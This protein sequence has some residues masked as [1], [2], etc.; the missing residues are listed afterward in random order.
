MDWLARYTRRSFLTQLIVTFVALVLV[1]AAA[2]G[3][4]A[5]YIISSALEKQAWERIEDAERITRVALEAEQARL[6]SVARLAAGRPSLQQLVRSGEFT[7][8]AEYLE[9]FRSGGAL[10]LLAVFDPLGRVLASSGTLEIEPLYSA[11]AGYRVDS[12]NR[13]ALV[14]SQS[15]PDNQSTGVAGYVVVGI[16]LDDDF[17]RQLAVETGFEQSIL[18]N[19]SRIATSLDNAPPQTVIPSEAQR[20]ETTNRSRQTEFT[21]RGIHYYA[22]FVP[23][24][25]VQGEVIGLVEIVM[26]VDSLMTARHRALLALAFSALTVAAVG[27]LLGSLYARWLTAPLKR[28]TLVAREIGHGDLRGPVPVL[29]RPVEFTTLAAA[30]DESR[31]KIRRTLDELSRVKTWSEMLIQSM[32]EGVVTFDADQHITF[33]SRGAA[34][35]T[36]WPSEEALKQPVGEVLNLPESEIAPLAAA[37]G[38]KRQVQITTRSG[39]RKTLAL[40][41]AK[42]FPPDSDTEQTVLVLRDITDED[43][44]RQRHSYF[45]GNITHEFRTPLSGLKASIELLLDDVDYLSLDEIHELLN[46]IHLSVSGLQALVDN[47]LESVNIEA[48]RFSIHRRPVDLNQVTAEAIRT[49]Q[50]LLDRRKQRLSLTEPL[51]LPPVHADPTRLRQVIINLLANASKYG[52]QDETIDL[53]LAQVDETLKI[54]VADRGPGIPPG[55]RAQLFNRFVRVGAQTSEQVGIGL[56]LSVVKAIVEGHGG[57]VGTDERPGGGSV[58]WFTLPLAEEA[59]HDESLDC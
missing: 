20:A 49:M 42:V 38:S 7:A 35:I 12:D 25:A 17:A 55:E 18:R 57:E 5:Y 21:M 8:L 59:L 47:L 46:S 37:P 6:A 24:L 1:T 19:T 54:T 40:T 48:G 29:G 56:G 10:D 4:P 41:G 45:L 23:L 34:R 53:E 51:Q 15:I 14:A 36:D 32:T 31:I 26:P 52:P 43:M 39:H 44:G 16:S 13:L 11:A 27:S 3:L 28:L 2:V 33:F 30:L 50:P 58:F 22:I 9:T